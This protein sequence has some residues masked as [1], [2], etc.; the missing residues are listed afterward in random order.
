MSVLAK[1]VVNNVQST[2]Q[3]HK[4]EGTDNQYERVEMRTV[5]FSPVYSQD[6]TSENHKFWNSSPTGVIKLGTIN[7]AAWQYFELGKEYY[8]EFKAAE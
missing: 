2:L 1:F 8:I 3:M 5:E 6:T 7:P 4:V